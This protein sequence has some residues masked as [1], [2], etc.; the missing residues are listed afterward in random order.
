MVS[1]KS[2]DRFSSVMTLVNTVRDTP[3]RNTACRP[4]NAV[5]TPRGIP[6]NSQGASAA[7]PLRDIR[8]NSSLEA[9]AATCP[10]RDIRLSSREPAILR[11]GSCHG[12]VICHPIRL[13]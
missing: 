6:P 7:S 1:I 10:H 13:A 2:K 5:S 12:L 11:G 4:L 9:N 3:Y 8:P